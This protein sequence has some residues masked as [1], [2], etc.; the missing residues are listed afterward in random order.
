MAKYLILLVA[1]VS[2]IGCS[3]GETPVETVKVDKAA[4]QT[5]SVQGAIQGNQNL[6]P[7]AKDALLHG[8]GK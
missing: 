7:A 4:P 5:D 3:A 8:G 2:I 1:T 6:P